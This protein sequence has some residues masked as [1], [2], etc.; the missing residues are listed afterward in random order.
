[1]YSTYRDGAERGDPRD[2][3]FSTVPWTAT[4]WNLL[5]LFSRYFVLSP[6]GCNG[7]PRRRGHIHGSV[8]PFRVLFFWGT[9][10]LY[11]V[12]T[13][14]HSSK[15]GPSQIPSVNQTKFI[16]VRP[17]GSESVSVQ[18]PV[19]ALDGNATFA[20]FG[21]KYANNQ[22]VHLPKSN[23]PF[24]SQSGPDCMLWTLI[25]P[26]NGLGVLVSRMLFGRLL[27]SWPVRA[28]H[29]NQSHKCVPFV[30]RR[31]FV[32]RLEYCYCNNVGYL[33]W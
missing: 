21:S 30:T 8:R 25:L 23:L 17:D 31:Y 7:L 3:H 1:M 32:P 19:S 5:S 2:G 29:L 20:F 10:S 12:F 33:K 28:A 4:K 18:S 24:C 11:F 6:L 14:F 22:L 16:C 15:I 13:P 26:R 9:L 27:L